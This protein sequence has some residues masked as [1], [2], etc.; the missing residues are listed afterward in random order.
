[1]ILIHRRTMWH[2]WKGKSWLPPDIVVM[3]ETTWH[4]GSAKHYHHGVGRLIISFLEGWLVHCCWTSPAWQ[5]SP[6]PHLK[7][8]IICCC[9]GPPDNSVQRYPPPCIQGGIDG[10]TSPNG[11]PQRWT[12][13]IQ[14]TILKVLTI[15][16]HFIRNFWIAD[17]P[18]TLYDGL[19][20]CSKLYTSNT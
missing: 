2:H 20:S 6:P 14:R 19:F 8:E 5:S 13:M 18:T 11:H 15:R 10:G 17:T 9:Q 1:M 12:P 7:K 16:L 3:K 4:L